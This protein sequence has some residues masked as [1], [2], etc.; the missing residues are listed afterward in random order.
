M[1]IRS[2]FSFRKRERNGIFF[3]LVFIFSGYLIIYV[4]Q[5]FWEKP[6]VKTSSNTS[7]GSISTGKVIPPE[8]I[9]RYQFN[10][11]FISDEKGYELGMSVEAI[12]RLFQ[13][14]EKGR[15]VN[16]PEE[17]QEITGISDSLLTVLQPSFRFPVRAFSTRKPRYLN[18]AKKEKTDL[19]TADTTMLSSVYGIGSRLANR[20]VK[21]RT[22]LGGFSNDSQLREV[23]GLK[24][25]VV[26]RL[27][28]RFTVRSL[29][30]IK[31][32]NINTATLQQ[33]RVIPYLNEQSAKII[34]KYRSRVGEIGDIDELTKIQGF[35]EEKINRIKVYLTVN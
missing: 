28:E 4:K 34:I 13:F 27:M 32:T 18:S 30:D 25:E 23:Y 35:P 2:R 21:Y 5:G 26:L 9:I 11:N 16:S 15:F 8:K 20:I 3:L 7:L 19:N 14:R 12:D 24:E 31:K 1:N 6:L 22:Y 33:L 10:P 17:F 29:P